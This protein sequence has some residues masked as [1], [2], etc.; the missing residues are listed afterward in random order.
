MNTYTLPN[1]CTRTREEIAAALERVAALDPAQTV[2]GW[3]CEPMPASAALIVLQDALRVMDE[4]R[5]FALVS[6]T[7][8]DLDAEAVAALA[9]ARKKRAED[10]LR[11]PM[12]CR[13][14]AAQGV[15][16]RDEENLFTGRAQEARA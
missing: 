16:F 10:A 8:S 6:P 4:G 3:S 9:K 15:F 12:G 2:T 14:F 5:G 1:G 13:G 11:A 7:V